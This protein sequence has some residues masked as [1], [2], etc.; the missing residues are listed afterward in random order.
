MKH[1]FLIAIDCVSAPRHRR[2][3]PVSHDQSPCQP[4]AGR[5]H[6]HTPC[7]TNARNRAVMPYDTRQAAPRLRAEA[8]RQS[9]FVP[10]CRRALVSDRQA[11]AHHSRTQC[12]RAAHEPSGGLDCRQKRL[13]RTWDGRW[14][15]SV[16]YLGRVGV[17]S[18]LLLCSL[19]GA[20]AVTPPCSQARAKRY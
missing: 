13:L 7:F 3:A 5:G 4:Q 15:E 10:R 12:G 6:S 1:C 17:R 9:H 2:C 18:V 11:F 19:A 14:E 20:T 8:R 16:A